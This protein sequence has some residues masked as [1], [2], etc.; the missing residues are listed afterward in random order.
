M[1][2][3]DACI[4]PDS[5]ESSEYSVF[6]TLLGRREGKGCDL[7]GRAQICNV[8]A[9]PAEHLIQLLS[10]TLEFPQN[11]QGLQNS[12]VIQGTLTWLSLV[13]V[14]P[15]LKIPFPQLFQHLLNA[16]NASM[17]WGGTV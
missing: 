13:P 5:P 11:L 9:L 6:A 3:I 7:C 17:H 16:W 12:Q 4:T 2:K 8:V 15:A 14:A 1:A 10:L